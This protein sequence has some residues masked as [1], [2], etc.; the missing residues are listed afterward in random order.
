[1]KRGRNGTDYETVVPGPRGVEAT[2]ASR[3]RLAPGDPDE[4]KDALS[5]A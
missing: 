5:R 2:V 1:M 4:V 3:R